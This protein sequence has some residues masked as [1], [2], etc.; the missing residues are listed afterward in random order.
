MINQGF[1]NSEI[2]QTQENSPN[3]QS[4]R[5]KRCNTTPGQLSCSPD[6][7]PARRG[8]LPVR[9]SVASLTSINEHESEDSN[10]SPKI[11]QYS[12]QNTRNGTTNLQMTTCT[13]IDESERV[14]KLKDVY[15]DVDMQ[16]NSLHGTFNAL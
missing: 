8:S 5:L 11:H 9:S 10:R 1:E 4:D 3:S 14:D 7:S 12:P 16:Q 6:S 13:T 2:L 15:I